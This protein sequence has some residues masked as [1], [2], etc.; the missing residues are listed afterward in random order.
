MFG[1]KK[2]IEDPNYW[3][4]LLTG[5]G[6]PAELPDE[7]HGRQ[8]RFGNGLGV[9]TEKEEDLEDKD[10]HSTMCPINLGTRI[11]GDLDQPN[12]RPVEDR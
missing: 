3:E 2:E 6:L 5:E 7:G 9:K 12:D 1:R 10:G 4:K 8:V 11:D